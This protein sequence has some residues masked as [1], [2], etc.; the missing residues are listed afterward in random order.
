M[1]LSSHKEN[2]LD[3]TDIDPL[4]PWDSQKDRLK[5][6]LMEQHV[7]KIGK[8]CFRSNIARIKMHNSSRIA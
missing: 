5:Q 2:T 1:L 4:S 6:D 3:S 7:K 8:H